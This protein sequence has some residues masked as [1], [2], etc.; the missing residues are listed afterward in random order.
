MKPK[1]KMIALMSIVILLAAAVLWYLLRRSKFSISGVL[2]H[3]DFLSDAERETMRKAAE[4]QKQI[5]EQTSEGAVSVW[6]KEYMDNYYYTEAMALV[7]LAAA[8][9]ETVGQM[10]TN[11]RMQV[12]TALHNMI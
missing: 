9:L 5:M 12:E 4:T 7:G 8:N 1:A 10:D 3:M 11:T 6:V 2:S